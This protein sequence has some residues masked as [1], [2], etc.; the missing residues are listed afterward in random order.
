MVPAVGQRHT[1]AQPT[2]AL[3]WIH[4]QGLNLPDPH[5]SSLINFLAN[6]FDLDLLPSEPLPDAG[7]VLWQR[8][9]GVRREVQADRPQ[10]VELWSHPETGVARKLVFEWQRHSDQLGVARITFDLLSEDP[11]PDSWYEADSHQ[12]LPIL[13]IPPIVPIAQP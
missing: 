7:N 4:K 13:P 6:Q 8:V 2:M 1:K 9:R 3:E 10:L 11:M 12:P 5:I